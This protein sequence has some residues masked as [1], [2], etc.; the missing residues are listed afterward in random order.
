MVL[1]KLLPLFTL[2]L[3][4]CQSRPTAKPNKVKTPKEER[5]PTS[6]RTKKPPTE[7]KARPDV[8]EPRREL[9]R[10][11]YAW[12]GAAL[13]A[14]S[15][16]E[17]LEQ[18]FPAPPGFSR[19]KL[20][21]GSFGAWLRGLPL[22]KKG[23]PVN[24]YRGNLLHAADDPR[25]AA[26]VAIDVGK[27]D[28]QQCADAVIRMHA[29]WS[30]QRGQRDMSYRA[31]AG[32]ALPYSRYAEGQ[33]VVP[34]GRSISWQPRGRPTTDYAGFRKYLNSVFAWANTVSLARQA[35]TPE[36]ADVRP[37][38]FFILPGNPGHA[39]L[40]VDMVEKNGMKRVLLAQSFMPAQNVQILRPAPGE[41]WFKLDLEAPTKTPFWSPFPW[42]SL[43]RLD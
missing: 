14:P 1:A 24:T 6:K 32:I 36:I 3:L 27:S 15:A 4:A 31:A 25:I 35:K 2:S 40:V 43:R 26:V 19:T 9:R 10:Q 28:L 33:R 21:K 23:T 34:A 11:D 8:A 13:D 7:K 29:E 42:S 30:W 5:R 38:D 39:V 12:L 37:G 41:V 18:R 22:A 17:S 20:E 16:V